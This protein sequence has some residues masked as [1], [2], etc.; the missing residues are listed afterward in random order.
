MA[1]DALKAH[2][3]LAAFKQAAGYY[4]YSNLSGKDRA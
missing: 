2:G 4:D 3:E 1:Y